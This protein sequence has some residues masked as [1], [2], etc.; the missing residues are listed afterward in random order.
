[1]EKIDKNDWQ[2]CCEENYPD[3][4]DECRRCAIRLKDETGEYNYWLYY[5]C[6]FGWSTL[7]KRDAECKMI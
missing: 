5:S 4:P 1:M 6:P 3:T 7:I 2:P